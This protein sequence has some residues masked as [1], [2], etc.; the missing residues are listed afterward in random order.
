MTAPSATNTKDDGLSVPNKLKK[1]NKE[2][3]AAALP[4]SEASIWDFLKTNPCGPI[5]FRVLLESRWA[6]RN[7]GPYSLLI[8]ETVDAWETAEG[9]KLRAPQLF[10]ALSELRQREKQ[11]ALNP[12]EAAEAIHVLSAEEI[13][14]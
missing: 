12:K 10:R 4:K 8:G 7:G 9:E 13:P 2:A 1:L 14:A 3:A 11:Q 6:S 5:S